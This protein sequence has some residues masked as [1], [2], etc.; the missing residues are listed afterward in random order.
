MNILKYLKE[1]KSCFNEGLKGVKEASK[2]AI[3]MTKLAVKD[4]SII[5]KAGVTGAIDA[6]K[7]L[8]IKENK[9]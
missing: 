3:K 2:P 5:I 1:L 7:K 6:S 8:G 9:S 4:C